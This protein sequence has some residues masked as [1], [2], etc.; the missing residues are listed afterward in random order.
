[1]CIYKET[2]LIF[3]KAFSKVI[4]KEAFETL[5]NDFFTNEIEKIHYQDYKK[6]RITYYIEKD[7]K[8]LFLFVN[9][10]KDDSITIKKELSK[11]KKKFLN[12]FKD[13]LPISTEL[14]IFKKFDE[15]IF[16]I[17]DNLSP[18]VSLVGYNTV[19]KTT[20]FNL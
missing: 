19:G 6:Y 20:L 16:S 11:C 5:I 13:V 8:L 2:L 1:M 3:E 10:I 17:Q 12:Y 4:E 18:I 14:N 9:D 15:I 7:F